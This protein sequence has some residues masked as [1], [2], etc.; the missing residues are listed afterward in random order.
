MTRLRPRLP[1]WTSSPGFGV[2]VLL[3]LAVILIVHGEPQPSSRPSGTS[4]GVSGSP[5]VPA[6]VPALLVIRPG[7]VE[8][9][10][11]HTVRRVRLRAAPRPLSVVTGRGLSVVLAALDG[12]QRAYAVQP[13]LA[14]RDLGPADA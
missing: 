11:G 9:R 14:V 10:Q 2:A 7:L 8:S 1:H 6:T 5:R 3:V 12:R 13:N 4:V